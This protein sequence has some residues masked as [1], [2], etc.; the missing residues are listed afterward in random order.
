M[1]K[2]PSQDNIL[3]FNAN[4]WPVSVAITRVFFADLY[5]N[6]KLDAEAVAEYFEFFLTGDDVLRKSPPRDHAKVIELLSKHLKTYSTT[7]DA[8][9]ELSPL[10]WSRVAIDF[11]LSIGG[12]QQSFIDA[13]SRWAF[14]STKKWPCWVVP[15]KKKT[16]TRKH[17]NNTIEFP[18]DVFLLASIDKA[19]IVGQQWRLDIRELPLLNS[20]SH[21]NIRSKN[22]IEDIVGANAYALI[23][24]SIIEAAAN[25][26]FKNISKKTIPETNKFRYT[27]QRRDLLDELKKFNPEIK[28]YSDSV[29]IKAISRLATCRVSW[30]KR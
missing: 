13:F 24:T 17:G 7:F 25:R 6:N 23:K 2:S 9:T 30:A 3:D 5:L 21:Q 8:T 18:L 11:W 10:T 12:R 28:K 14:E 1:K 29:V 16:K 27:G 20:P 26:I 4:T 22:N 19:S 15:Q